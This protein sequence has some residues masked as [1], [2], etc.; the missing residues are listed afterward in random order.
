MNY[1]FKDHLL[2]EAEGLDP[3]EELDNSA[4]NFF[5]KMEGGKRSVA[6]IADMLIKAAGGAGAPRIANELELL[7]MLRTVKY[8]VMSR[9]EPF[10]EKE[11]YMEQRKDTD[12]K[13]LMASIEEEVKEALKLEFPKL[14]GYVNKISKILVRPMLEK[15]AAYGPQKFLDLVDAEDYSQLADDPFGH[16][17]RYIINSEVKSDDIDAQVAQKVIQ[18]WSQEARKKV[19]GTKKSRRKENMDMIKDVMDDGYAEPAE[20]KE[21]ELRF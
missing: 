3:Q 17:S 4:R 19:K 2:M 16:L 20:D 12:H 7:E 8:V 18:Q 11:D 15:I 14:Q 6:Q 9:L 13:L 5:L 1:S 10:Y 21:D